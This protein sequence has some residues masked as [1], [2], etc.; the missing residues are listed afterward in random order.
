MKWQLG[1]SL[2]N[3]GSANL[4]VFPNSGNMSLR[5]TIKFRLWYWENSQGFSCP[6]LLSEVSFPLYCCIVPHPPH[7]LGLIS[8]AL[9]VSK[10]CLVWREEG[11]KYPVQEDICFLAAWTVLTCRTSSYWPMNKPGCR[12]DQELL[13]TS[14]VRGGN[15]LV[16]QALWTIPTVGSVTTA[17]PITESTCRKGRSPFNRD[18]YRVSKSP[19]SGQVLGKRGAFISW[20]WI[21]ETANVGH[22]SLGKGEGLKGGLVSC[23]G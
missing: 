21:H 9:L 15:Q 13:L 11:E 2:W 23:L 20:R 10:T 7:P 12:S 18:L 5:I 17:T 1:F 4:G 6:Q 8:L 22:G 14:G 3:E 16:P 19:V